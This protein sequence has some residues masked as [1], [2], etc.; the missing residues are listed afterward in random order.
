[1]PAGAH[2]IDADD[3]AYAREHDPRHLAAQRDSTTRRD[4][5]A[6]EGRPVWF[7]HDHRVTLERQS[8]NSW[9]AACVCRAAQFGRQCHHLAVALD[10]EL[11]R[12]ESARVHG[13]YATAKHE[14]AR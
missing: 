14:Q 8:D 6:A 1:M 2:R 10:E 5:D 11:V 7:V 9:L 4:P 13:A 12:R 3:V